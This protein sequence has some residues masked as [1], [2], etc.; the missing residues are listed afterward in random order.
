MREGEGGRERGEMEG[1]K[2]GEGGRQYGEKR[3]GEKEKRER[4]RE[5]GWYEREEEGDREREHAGHQ[6]NFLQNFS[7]IN[8]T[9]PLTE[10]HNKSRS[11]II[12]KKKK[13]PYM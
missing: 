5:R 8:E 6:N 12:E 10:R 1:G 9:K 3:K 11:I 7:Q 4:K 2:E 13:T